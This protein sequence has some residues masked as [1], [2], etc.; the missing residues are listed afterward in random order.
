M[1]KTETEPDEYD[2]PEEKKHETTRETVESIVIA[3]VL[4][5]LFRTFEAEAFVIPTGSM[6]PTLFGRHKDVHCDKCGF[7]FE[8]GASD[9]VDEGGFLIDGRRVNLARCPNCRYENDVLNLP[10]YKGDRILVNKFPYEFNDPERWDVVVFKYPEGPATNY[11]K[12]LVGLPGESIK[13]YRGDVYAREGGEGE[14]NILR[15][16]DP[17]KQRSLQ[18]MVYDA[19]FPETELYE[20]GWPK[21]WVGMKYDPDLGVPGNWIEDDAGWKVEDGAKALSISADATDGDIKWA[22]YRHIVPAPSD[23]RTLA[24]GEALNPPRPSR[25]LD[26]C[27]YNTYTHQRPDPP[28]DYGS[29]WVGDLSIGFDVDISSVEEN[30]KLIVELV[31][32]VRWYRCTFD[33]ESGK[34]RIGFID[35]LLSRDAE[36]GDESAD[37]E[38]LIGEADSPITGT[39]KYSIYFANVDDR[40]S[41]WVNESLIQFEQN[42]E[43]HAPALRDD[44]EEDRIPVGIGAVGLTATA[45]QFELY[46]D[47]YYR[48]EVADPS[49]AHTPDPEP[50]LDDSE[51]MSSP[52]WMEL[53]DD[54]FLVLGDNSPRSKDSR[55]WGNT[56]R[57]ERRHAVPR[58]ALIGKAFYIYWPHGVPFTNNGEGFALFKHRDG[59]GQKTDYPSFR[60][61]FYPQVDRMNRIR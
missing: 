10:V 30:G 26:Y 19:D 17:N 9:E 16:Q 55:L 18:I 14:A 48:S 53:A 61:P 29:R 31:E 3:F 42:G 15:K 28:Y 40:L 60:V 36:V 49:F 33:L 58:D 32:G 34:V 44:T 45:S 11:I 57:A 24:E 43:Y 39:G 41:L 20:A 59:K 23:W 2:Q 12:R 52:G 25:V 47:I 13:I 38:Q 46:R 51:L 54:E 35:R 5:F 1:A 27:A 4:A 6:A 37:D 7:N 50:Q 22:R 8:I 56:R 21:R